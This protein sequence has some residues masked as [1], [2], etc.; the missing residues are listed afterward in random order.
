MST[1]LQWASDACLLAGSFLLLTGALIGFLAGGILG[2][3]TFGPLGS[4]VGSVLGV[5]V[6]AF[7]L[8]TVRA[9]RELERPS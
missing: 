8:W 6:G 4:L 1:L 2:G 7:I 5:P 3:A 9:S